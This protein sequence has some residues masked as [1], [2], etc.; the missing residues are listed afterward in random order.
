VLTP[1]TVS[2]NL[3]DKTQTIETECCHAL[4]EYNKDLRVMQELEK[5]CHISICWMPGC[6]DWEDRE[7]GSH[8]QVSA[9][10]ILT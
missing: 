4:E 10:L 5:K 2:L 9:S 6:E 7:D 3:R 1:E 8:A